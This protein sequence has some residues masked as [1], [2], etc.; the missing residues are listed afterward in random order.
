MSTLFIGSGAAASGDPRIREAMIAHSAPRFIANGIDYNDF[1]ATVLRLRSAE[2]WLDAWQAV[3]TCH[4]RLAREAEERS[5]PFAGE[6]CVRAALCHHFGKFLYFEGGDRPRA[7]AATRASVEDYTRAA[8]YLN[9]PVER[10]TIPYDGTTLPGLLRRPRGLERPPVVVLVDGLDWVKEEFFTFEPLFH[11]HGL[12][13]L[14]FDGPGQG[15]SEFDLAIEPAYEKPVTAVVDWLQQR[16][17]VDGGRVGV[18]GV[19]LGG[20]Y[21]ARAAAYEPRLRCVVP[22]SGPYDAGE[23]F[24]GL[25]PVTRHA[26]MVRGHAADEP[27]AKALAAR[28]TLREA[29]RLIKMPMLVVFGK[30]DDLFPPTHAERLYADAGSEDKQ[31]VL[32]EDG[33]HVCCNVPYACRPLVADWVAERLRRA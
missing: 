11:R 23:A 2:D 16:Q 28:V 8:P 17:D 33:D 6:A 19:S 29:A 3:A 5:S 1:Q 22:I 26:I 25:P 24:D 10:V 27:A 9:P 15:E 20:Y 32:F 14:A 18:V 7:R 13:T 31:L 30:K 4:E 21:V 12:A